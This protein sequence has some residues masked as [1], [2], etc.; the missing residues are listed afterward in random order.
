MKQNITY[1]NAYETDHQIKDLAVT[2]NI[3]H[4]LGNE[5]APQTKIWLR[6]RTSNIKMAVRQNITLYKFGYAT[7]HRT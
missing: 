2:R 5:T 4:E 1:R 3:Q 6:S 7:E